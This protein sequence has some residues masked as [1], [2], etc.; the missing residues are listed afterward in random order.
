MWKHVWD[1]VGP[2]RGRNRG[3]VEVCT[4]LVVFLT[5]SPALL[6]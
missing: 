3:A 5:G 6:R 1:S 2:R 4:T